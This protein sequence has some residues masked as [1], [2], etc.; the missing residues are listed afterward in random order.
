MLS[1]LEAE[2]LRERQLAGLTDTRARPGDRSRDG[3]RPARGEP[4]RTSWSMTTT[5]G[6]VNA[7]GPPVLRRYAGE[8]GSPRHSIY[9]GQYHRGR[10]G[11]SPPLSV[12]AIGDPVAMEQSCGPEL[13]PLHRRAASHQIRMVTPA[14]VPGCGLRRFVGP[15]RPDRGVGQWSAPGCTWR[16]WWLDIGPDRRGD[17]LPQAE[18]AR[19]GIG[20]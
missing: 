13:A 10:E 1:Q 2:V 5:C 15:L 3:D 12:R 8:S 6:P 18:K 17:P 7:L 20:G 16:C 19:G 9:R 14:R 11:V 4:Q